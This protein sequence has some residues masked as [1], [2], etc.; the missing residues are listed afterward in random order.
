MRIEPKF[1]GLKLKEPRMCEIKIACFKAR[2]F[3]MQNN[4]SKLLIF[5]FVC[6]RI[7]ALLAWPNNDVDKWTKICQLKVSGRKVKNISVFF[8]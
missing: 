2:F 1:R 6:P 7:I 3:Q 8:F 5:R 4:G